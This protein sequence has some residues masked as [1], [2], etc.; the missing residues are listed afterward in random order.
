LFINST[1]DINERVNDGKSIAASPGRRALAHPPI[2]YHPR[3][4]NHLYTHQ[5]RGGDV[6]E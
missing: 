1:T 2:S 3:S 4:P 6:G 5:R